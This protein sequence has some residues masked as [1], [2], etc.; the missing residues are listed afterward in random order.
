MDV[1]D[2]IDDIDNTTLCN[3]TDN[4]NM[5]IE[6]SPILFIA[7]MLIPCLLSILCLIIIPIY[8]IVKNL[9]NK[10]IQY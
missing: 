1:I 7:I 8:T 2:I 9:L 4:N 10:N 5:I 6:I 3:C